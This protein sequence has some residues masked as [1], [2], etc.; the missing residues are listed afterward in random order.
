MCKPQHI[1]EERHVARSQQYWK[2]DR[3]VVLVELVDSS[4][5]VA[6]GLK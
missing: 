2:P 6:N 3:E 4:E 1:H 5:L